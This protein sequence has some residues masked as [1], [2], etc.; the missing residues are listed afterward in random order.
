M[1]IG[2]CG[3][4]GYLHGPFYQKVSDAFSGACRR[5]WGNVPIIIESRRVQKLRRAQRPL[6]GKWCQ[7]LGRKMNDLT[8]NKREAVE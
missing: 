3:R 7:D 8:S 1:G 5:S 6:G 4:L 2:V